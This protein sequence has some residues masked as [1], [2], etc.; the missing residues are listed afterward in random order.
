MFD[1]STSHKY[2]DTTIPTGPGLPD[3]K[4]TYTVLKDETVSMKERW[5]PSTEVRPTVVVHQRSEQ[6]GVA[7]PG[8]VKRDVSRC[9]EAFSVQLFNSLRHDQMSENVFVSPY[10]I[11]VALGMLMAGATRETWEELVSTMQ[12]RAFMRGDYD[13]AFH[14]AMRQ[15]LGSATAAGFRSA[16][17]IWVNKQS[18]LHS[19]FSAALDEFYEAC[20]RSVDFSRD[21]DA[22]RREINEWVAA[23]TE[24]RI[25]DL[26]PAGSISG[27]T[28]AVLCNAIYFNEKW[29]E[30][31]SIDQVLTD[32]HLTGSR[33]VKQ[34]TYISTKQSLRY[35]FDSQI[36]AD[37][38]FVPYLNPAAAA[39]IIVPRKQEGLATMR[40][41]EDTISSAFAQAGLPQEVELKLPKFKFDTMTELSDQL[42]LIGAQRVFS[43]GEAQL[44]RMSN[45]G[46]SV[47][48]VF[49]GAFVSVDENGTEA[50]AATAIVCNTYS[51]AIE[52]DV[53]K[54]HA[55][56][57]FI[58][59]LVNVQPDGW[60]VSTVFLGAVNEP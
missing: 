37:I 51:C 17:S 7:V 36:N 15:S 42:K 48:Q 49:H 46:V 8:T 53:I 47:S 20:G 59:G 29:A 14:A 45:C 6:V 60:N 58:F 16:N 50:A 34:V 10:S 19:S 43:P 18:D 23:K 52:P 1:H 31:F 41:A 2:Q 38:V 35:F 33:G 57:P 55:E 21:P 27:T 30:K 26:L 11:Y 39:V 25:Q 4:I 22:A 24:Q 13:T 28:F 40:L 56:H 54:V 9:C 5:V 32:F 3:T 12:A 44:D